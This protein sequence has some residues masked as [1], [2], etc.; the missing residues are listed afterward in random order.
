MAREQYNKEKG[1]I[2]IRAP[3]ILRIGLDSQGEG[4]QIDWD[5]NRHQFLKLGTK[6]SDGVIKCLEELVYLLKKERHHKEI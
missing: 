1:G 6:T 3:K 4:I 5:N 2:N